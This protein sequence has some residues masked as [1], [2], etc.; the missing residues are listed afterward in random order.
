A[1]T[2]TRGLTLWALILPYIEQGGLAAQLDYNAYGHTDNTTGFIRAAAS[3]TNFTVLKANTLPL[4]TCPS[5]RPKGSKNEMGTSVCDYAIITYGGSRWSFNSNPASQRQA[6][7]AAVSPSNS[8]LSDWSATLPDPLVG[9]APRDTMA[10]IADGTSNTALIGEKHIPSGYVGKCCSNN[11]NSHD[12]YP[13]YNNS[14]GP[15]GW[16]E[17]SIAGPIENGLAKSP[18]DGIG[19]AYETAPALGSWH[20]GICNFVFA[21]GSVRSIVTSISQT[22]LNSMGSANS[23]DLL[24]LD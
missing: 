15:N 9:W 4:H 17:W 11:A 2:G 21:D 7:R 19:I 1:I 13:Y 22:N 12:F 23:G 24:Q 8:N 18:T 6:I 5:R 3:A 20:T 10:Y 16:H 14:G